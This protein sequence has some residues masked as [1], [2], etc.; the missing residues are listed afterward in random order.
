M[1]LIISAG[2]GSPLFRRRRWSCRQFDDSV[3]NDIVIKSLPQNFIGIS[4][5]TRRTQ[6]RTLCLCWRMYNVDGRALLIAHDG[7]VHSAV[8]LSGV[9]LRCCNANE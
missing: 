1:A 8:T 3:Y 6:A 4:A 5:L 7:D 9:G 2:N